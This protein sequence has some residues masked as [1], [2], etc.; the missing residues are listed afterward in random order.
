MPG[1]S[2]V[3]RRLG[4]SIVFALLV[5]S[6][7]GTGFA[8]EAIPGATV[9][10]LLALAKARNPDL[11][12]ARLEAEAAE[13][14][15]QP[16]GAL[17]DP[18]LRVELENLTRG[19]TTGASLS[20]SR[21]GDTKYTLIQSLPFWGK[22][23]LREK[24][25]GAQ[26]QEAQGK[27][28]DAWLD[29][30]SRIQ[31]TYAEYWF[32]ARNLALNRELLD[33]VDRLEKVAQVRYGSG[34]AP[35]QDA[36]RAQLER[37][38]LRTEILALE[39]ERRALASRLNGLLARPASAALA[40]PQTLR[41][42]PAHM[43]AASLEQRLAVRNPALAMEAARAGAAEASRDLAYRNRY[44]D[45]ALGVAPMQVGNGVSS[46]SLMLEMNLPLQQGT[47]RSQERE[48]EQSLEAARAR[49]DGTLNRLRSELEGSLAALES[50]RETEKL[51]T[52]SLL[53]QARLTLESA[54]V[55]YE[56]G[57]VDFATVLEAER[58]L[59]LAKLNLYKAGATQ[60]LR[61]ADMERL[62]G[63]EP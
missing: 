20:P 50:A 63:E 43:D 32:N 53:P 12:A 33:L 58:Q 56:N 40:E 8:A 2:S 36:I 42:L 16:A 9:D 1:F 52:E 37:T 17:P 61:L 55:G 57:K 6:G 19:G 54:L 60:R 4:V 10:S 27:A 34:V 48:A 31:S 14:R 59:R 7:S 13:A 41:V 26:A 44:P 51:V 22:R 46:W 18:V 25:A 47:R 38:T 3:S 11:A 21:V 24:R 62:V 29:L 30:S 23:D 45:F 5:I 28:D 39:S 49:Q 15:V 35:Q